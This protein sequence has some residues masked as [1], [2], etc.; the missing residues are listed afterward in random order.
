MAFAVRRPESVAAAVAALGEPDPLVISGG[1][2]AIRGINEGRLFPASVVS[3]SRAGLSGVERCGERIKIGAATPI[4]ALAHPELGFLASLLR[5]FGSPALRNMACV[6]GNLFAPQPYGDLGV[7]LLALEASVAIAGPDGASEMLLGDFYTAPPAATEIVTAVRFTLPAAGTWRW[8]KATRRA[9]N[10]AAVVAIAAVIE[11][12]DSDV[13]RS[14]RIALG[15][16]DTVPVRSP[17]AEAALRGRVL[18]AASAMAAGE[19]A[20]MAHPFF[21]D[22]HASTWYRRRVLPVFM[23]RALLGPDRGAMR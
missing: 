5:S 11:I 1:T 9:L 18:D 23:R 12:D 6:G 21:A 10:A 7:A 15:G 22:A 4:A 3:L 17:A 19:A 8:L 13:V 16:V 20:R 14:V 2:I